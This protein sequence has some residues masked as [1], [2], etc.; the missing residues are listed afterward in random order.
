MADVFLKRNESLTIQAK[1]LIIV[2]VN[3]KIQAK[4][5]ILEN[6]YLS[7]RASQFSKYLKSFL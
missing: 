3:D 4:I 7:Q 2:V 5:R 6:L 1:Q